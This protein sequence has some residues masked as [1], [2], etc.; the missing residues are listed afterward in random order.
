MRMIR[1]TFSFLDC[2]LFKKLYTTFVRP[3]LEYAHPVWS[4]HLLK[5]ISII[6]NVQQRATKLVD[7]LHSYSYNERLDLPTLLYRRERG[8]LIEDYKHFHTYDKISISSSFRPRNRPSRTHDF[9]LHTLLP[10]DGTR[11]VQSNSFYYR[12][13]NTW[14]NLPKDVVTAPSINIFKNKLD[15]HWKEPPIKFNHKP[16]TIDS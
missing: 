1:R 8:D 10:K 13:S 14:N 15:G 11:G 5:H 9:Q 4:P 3:H 12:V 2:H 6:E 7:G 16:T